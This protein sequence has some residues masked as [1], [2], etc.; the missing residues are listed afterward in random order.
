MRVPLNPFSIYSLSFL[1]SLLLYF[2]DY[3]D[4]YPNLSSELIFFVAGTVF[5]SFVF[6]FFSNSK[7]VVRDAC[8]AR[9]FSKFDFVSFVLLSFLLVAEFLYEKSIPFFSI[10]RGGFDYKDFGIPFF[11]VLFVVFNYYLC[12]YWFDKYKISSRRLFLF[13]SMICLFYFILI[14]NRGAVVGCF[15]AL[16]FLHFYYSNLTLKSFLR[17][18]VIVVIFI[19]VFGQLGNLRSSAS[20]AYGSVDDLIL[21]IGGANENFEQSNLPNEAFWFYIY[22]SSPLAN[23]QN[24]LSDVKP[25]NDYA[26]FLIQEIIPDF[27]SKRIYPDQDYESGSLIT[28]EL[29]VSTAYSRGYMSMGWPGVYF[30]FGFFVVLVVLSNFLLSGTKHY[31][32]GMALL[33]TVSSLM[34]FTNTLV[35]SGFVLP[36]Y[37]SVV[38][39]VVDKVISGRRISK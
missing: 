17:I 22:L 39:A 30:Q 25:R 32:V 33:T 16:A 23:F 9:V 5:I 1:G 28:P 13:L 26:D 15:I 4:L 3:S 2:L 27:V 38:L 19:F 6:S 35:Y 18:I 34:V 24:T 14:F 36:F 20:S 21:K 10:L 29:T 7:V 11:H 8:R 12:V 37:F 31:S